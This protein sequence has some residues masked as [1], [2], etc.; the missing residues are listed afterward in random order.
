[1]L[2]GVVLSKCFVSGDRVFGSYEP[3]GLANESASC[4][5]ENRGFFVGDFT[6]EALVEIARLVQSEQD[7]GLQG[8]GVEGYEKH[9]DFGEERLLQVF[10]R[11]QHYSNFKFKWPPSPPLQ[12]LPSLPSTCPTLATSVRS[13]MGSFSSPRMWRITPPRKKK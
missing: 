11:F 7:L 8:K 3:E 5:E 10:Q 6:G 1:M 4:C 13:E 12:L 2:V 9:R